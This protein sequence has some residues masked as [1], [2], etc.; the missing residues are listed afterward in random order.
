M[1]KR[2]IDSWQFEHC[3]AYALMIE[4]NYVGKFL[5]AYPKGGAE[6]LRAAVSV[7]PGVTENPLSNCDFSK[8]GKAG[9]GGY[10]K[11][12][13]ALLDVLC[14]FGHDAKDNGQGVESVFKGFGITAIRIV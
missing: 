4:G 12:T 2:F 8:V 7:F 13:A 11:E 3:R 9:G 1:S 6:M 5:V 14:Q 10:D